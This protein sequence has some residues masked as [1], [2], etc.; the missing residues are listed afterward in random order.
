MTPM[1]EQI[2][3][4]GSLAA[5][6]QFLGPSAEDALTSAFEQLRDAA[7][8]SM[9]RIP[10]YIVIWGGLQAAWE[11]A[12]DLGDTKEQREIMKQRKDMLA[13]LH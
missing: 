1:Q 2:I 13:G 10:E 3:K 7:P 8:E 5:A 4:H 6:V 11:R 12:W 9:Q